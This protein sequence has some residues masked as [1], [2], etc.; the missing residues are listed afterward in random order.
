MASAAVANPWSL[1]LGGPVPDVSTGKGQLVVAGRR[2]HTSRDVLRALGVP[3]LRQGSTAHDV[4]RD[5]PIDTDLH[6]ARKYCARLEA[7][8]AAPEEADLYAELYRQA[9]PDPAIEAAAAKAQTAEPAQPADAPACVAAA[10][11]LAERL[12]AIDADTSLTAKQKAAR[13]HYVRNR[14]KLI[15]KVLTYQRTHRE[16]LNRRDRER[17]ARARQAK[18]AAACERMHAQAAKLSVPCSP[19]PQQGQE[20]SPCA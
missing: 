20:Q 3:S 14:D 12:A 11:D 15:A 7:L 6:L 8:G 13:R 18:F 17:A 9:T 2:C 10:P 19:E 5:G 1:M 4:E 16:Q